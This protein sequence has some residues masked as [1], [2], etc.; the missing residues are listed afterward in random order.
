MSKI[1]CKCCGQTAESKFRQDFQVIPNC[2]N[3]SMVGGGKDYL[4]IGGLDLS[5]IEVEQ[6]DGSF[7]GWAGRLR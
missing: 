2:P 3:E 5:L 6:E 1:R 4:R 7:K